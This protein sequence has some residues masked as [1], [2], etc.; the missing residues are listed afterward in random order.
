M[1]LNKVRKIVIFG[2]GTSGWLTAAFMI[3]NL[4]V[5]TQITLIEDAQAGPIG[6]GEGT[7][8]LTASFLYQCGIP[9]KM[10]MKPSSASLKYGVELVGWTNES[11]FV[12]NDTSD[13]CVIAEDFYTPDYFIDKPY[14]EFKN[15]HP[16]YRLAKKNVCQKFEDYLDVNPH[17]GPQHF[18]AVHFSALDIIKTIKEIIGDKI[19]Y[20]DTKIKE[21]TVNQEGIE[22]LIGENGNTYSADLFIDCTGFASVLLEQHLKVPFE[23]YNKWLPNDKAVVLPTQ[24]KDPKE[25]CFPYTRATAMNAGWRFTIPVY[26]RTGNGYVYSSKYLTPEEAEKELRDSVGE[27]DAPAKHL[28]MKCGL[29]KEIAYKNV[30]AVGLSAGFV[31]PLEATG[32]TFTTGT[33]NMLVHSLNSTGNVWGPRIRHVINEGFREM[34]TEILAFVWAHYHFSTKDDTPYWKEIRNQKLSDLPIEAR[35]IIEQF[36]PRPKRFLM[37]GPNSMFNIVQWFSM[38]H[39]GGAFEGVESELTDRKKKYAEYYLKHISQ[40]VDLAE[41]MFENQHDYLTRWYKND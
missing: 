35:T 5:P 11:Y 26:T 23:S 12:D 15:W 21:I 10:W 14:S 8:P 20:V 40:R 17:M 36:L 4:Q 39:A 41:E 33:V 32:I 29:H 25:D 30:C 28:T 1:L 18:G 31:E 27:Y 22:S 3:K 34:A 16:A 7:Q 37:L 13:N 2:G 24:F 9:P 38:L 6:V 19:T